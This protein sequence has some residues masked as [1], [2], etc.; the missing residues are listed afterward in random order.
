LLFPKENIFKEPEEELRTE[1]Y[2]KE[3]I[4]NIEIT[5]PEHIDYYLNPKNIISLIDM[6]DIKY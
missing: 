1:R 3:L 2:V 5:K 4:K 6:T